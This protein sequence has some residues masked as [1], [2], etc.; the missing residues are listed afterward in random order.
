MS[1][2]SQLQIRPK[3]AE[4][5]LILSSAQSS[6]AARGR[7]DA[8]MLTATVGAEPEEQ[9][10]ALFSG[11]YAW[12]DLGDLTFDE[13]RKR[14]EMGDARYQNVL[15]FNYLF[16]AGKDSAKSLL[17]YRKAADQGYAPAQFNLGWMFESNYLSDSE[18]DYAEAAEWYRK[19]ADQG[20]APAQFNLGAMYDTGEG[21]PQ[22]YGEAIKWYRKSAD[23]GLAP[24]QFNLGLKYDKGQGVARDFAQAIKWFRKAA[25]Q[26]NLPAQI[27]LGMRYIGGQGVAQD[28]VRAYMWMDLAE[29]NTG[30]DDRVRYAAMRDSVAGKMSPAQ[31][32]EARHLAGLWRLKKPRLRTNPA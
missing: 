13:L 19:A 4:S 15:A 20:F 30:E 27:T 7:R 5:S 23:Q 3:D 11:T 28:L 14:A 1:D 16:G 26:G 24:A 2:E 31:V 21:M 22:D 6:L 18:R 9:R 10:H 29:S 32:A 8:A 17:W 12:D 25:D